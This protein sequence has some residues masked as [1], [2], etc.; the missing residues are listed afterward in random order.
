[1]V[2]LVVTLEEQHQHNYCAYQVVF[3]YKL[4]LRKL[5]KQSM[6][7]FLILL[8]ALFFHCSFGQADPQKIKT[9]AELTAQ[10]LLK[11][12]YE[13]F[14][15]F[16]YPKV[17]EMLGGKEKMMAML[18]NG[19]MEMEQQGIGFESVTIGTPSASVQA[20]EEIHCLVPQTII[21]KIPNGKIKTET[22]LLAIS[23][24]N[25]GRWFFIDTSNLKME[26]VTKVLPNYNTDLI[27]PTKKQ[28]EM[29]K[30]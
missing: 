11:G 27:I 24:D 28:P 22:F 3:L 8:L 1:L 30:E 16:T 2:R 12:D 13:T 15:E 18:K 5:T 21:M 17:I 23:P 29:I 14:I 10:A 26:N 25:G 19:T 6:R 4:F 9:Q 20:G 7:L